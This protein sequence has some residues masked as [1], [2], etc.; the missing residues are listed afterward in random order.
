MKKYRISDYEKIC[1]QCQQ[2]LINV[3]G[4]YLHPDVECSVTDGVRI[5]L[6]D[7]EVREFME[8]YGSPEE[9]EH[10]IRE[11]LI[12]E[13]NL[14]INELDLLKARRWYEWLWRSIKTQI[15]RLKRLNSFT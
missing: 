7:K 10:E 6:K 14:L 8:E 2:P 3:A 12:K 13:L 5:V 11:G 4:R 15:G 1:I 9:S